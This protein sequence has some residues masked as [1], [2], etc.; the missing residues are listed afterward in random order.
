MAL[1]SS[2]NMYEELDGHKEDA[3]NSFK[4]IAV[5]SVCNCGCTWH[6]SNRKKLQVKIEFSHMYCCTKFG[7]I[8]VC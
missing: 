2:S 7:S 5:V 1:Y 8:S 3:P 4:I 6:K